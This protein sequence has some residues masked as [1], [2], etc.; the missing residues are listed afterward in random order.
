MAHSHP[1]CLIVNMLANVVL[2]M[3]CGPT[4]SRHFVA[5]A[6]DHIAWGPFP[7]GSLNVA[8]PGLKEEQAEQMY[9]SSSF[10]IGLSRSSASCWS[11]V[12]SS[13]GNVTAAKQREGEA[14]GM[15]LSTR[16]EKS[17]KEMGKEGNIKK[18][19]TWRCR[20]ECGWNDSGFI[21]YSFV[22]TLPL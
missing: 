17:T 22:Y 10:P 1:L 14:R 8:Y 2:A 13:A 11:T 9:A 3:W 18:K 16:Q 5:P 12:F 21:F 6:R 4:S 15:A 20:W 7:K 19:N